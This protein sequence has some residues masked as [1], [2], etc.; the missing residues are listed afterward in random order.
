MATLNDFKT[1]MNKS[2]RYYKYLDIQK[3]GISEAHKA[4]LGFYIFALECITNNKEIDELKEMI[5]DTEYNSIVNGIKNDDLGIDAVDINEDTRTINL[6]NFKCRENFSPQKGLALNDALISM[7]FVNAFLNPDAEDLEPKTRG[8]VEKISER[9]NSD[10]IWSMNLYMVSNENYGFSTESSAINDLKA[11]YGLEV[12]TYTLDDFSNFISSRPEPIKAKMI[13]D[14]G[15]ILTYEE[16]ALSSSKSYLIKLPV[17]ELIRITCREKEIRENYDSHIVKDLNLDFSVLF[18]N[19]RGYLGETKFNDNM[20]NTLKEEPTKFF[21]YNNG[22]TMTAKNIEVEEINGNVKIALSLDDFQVVNGGQTLRT[23]Y[24]FKKENYDEETL[25]KAY[26]LIRIFKTGSD[27]D[28]TNKIAEYTNSQNAISSKDLKSLD[29]IQM[30]IEH[31]LKDHGYL[32]VRKVGDTGDNN[33]DYTKRITMEK[34]GQILYSKQGYP[35]RATSQKKKIFDTRYSEIFGDFDI[36][37][38]VPLVEKY[39]EIIEKYKEMELVINDQ[40]LYYAIYL[41][42]KSSDLQ[43]NIQKIEDVLGYYRDSDSLSEAR[44]L[45]QKGF[46]EEIDKF[47]TE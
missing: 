18:D 40:K 47:Y 43:A 45:I 4:R 36:D 42:E 15:S 34:F 7:K 19:V 28:L 20:F 22:L 9:L 25:N 23:L 31:E 6:F 21:M 41:S 33:E 12:K 1:V 16:S 13:L 8:F 2:K 30:K 38:A 37:T 35:D 17:A 46:R 11:A 3:K 44:K 5:N 39:F 14:K 27:E 26:V 29:A 24:D 10:K 32:Y